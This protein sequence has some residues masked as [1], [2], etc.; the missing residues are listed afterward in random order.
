MSNKVIDYSARTVLPGGAVLGAPVRT[1][2]VAPGVQQEAIDAQRLTPFVP[3]QADPSDPEFLRRIGQ[4]VFDPGNY[5]DMIIKPVILAAGVDQLAIPRPQYERIYIL[6]QNNTTG[7]VYMTFDNAATLLNG[8]IIA[9]GGN[10]LADSRVPQNDLHLMSP[11]G[12][13]VIA[14]YMNVDIANA[15]A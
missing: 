5:G 6:I 3:S 15:R 13:N 2:T 8:I 1:S 11:A 7:F 12:G 4:S 10:Y 14:C 9:A